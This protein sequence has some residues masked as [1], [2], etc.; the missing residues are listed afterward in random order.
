VEQF[1][2]LTDP[3]VFGN[4]PRTPVTLHKNVK[5]E[6]A[7]AGRLAE[8]VLPRL[9]YA[10][11]KSGLLVASVGTKQYQASPLLPVNTYDVKM[12]GVKPTKLELA[13]GDRLL[14]QLTAAG[15][16]PRLGVPAFAHEFAGRSAARIPTRGSDGGGEPVFLTLPQVSAVTSPKVQTVDLK[17]TAA[18]ERPVPAGGT[19]LRLLR[20]RLAWFDV[21]AADGKPPPYLRVENRA[22]GPVAPVWDLTLPDWDENRSSATGTA[23]VRPPVVSGY[24]IDDL[25][26]PAG[27]GDLD[28]GDFAP[29][30]RALRDRKAYPGAGGAD[31]L[32]GAE[33]VEENG[34]KHLLVRWDYDQPGQPVF[35]RVTG[36]KKP[37][38]ERHRYYDASTRYTVRFGPLTADD[39]KAKVRLELYTVADL[40]KAGTGVSIPFPDRLPVGP[41]AAMPAELLLPAR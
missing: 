8:A 32:R 1:E 20:P 10:G 39:L 17:L 25:P 34:Q 29:A 37:V 6:T 30:E 16:N 35:A 28:L 3:T 18:L 15:G 5:D 41:A 26:A 31:R 21:T 9:R 4:N 7:F 36:W 11:P 14:L 40:R 38:E 19:T 24:W 23:T 12:G 27:A 2:S 13:A 22:D 33:V